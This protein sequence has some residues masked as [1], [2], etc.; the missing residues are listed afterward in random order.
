MK[1]KKNKMLVAKY[2]SFQWESVYKTLTRTCGK[3]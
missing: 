3:A 2:E 1:E